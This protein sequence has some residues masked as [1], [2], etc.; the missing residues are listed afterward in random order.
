MIRRLSKQS[1]TKAARELASR[2]RDL[3]RLIAA[4]GIPPLW[5]RQPGFSTLIRIILEQQV[6]LASAKA[7][8]ERLD[9]NIVPFGPHRFLEV[10]SSYLRSVGITRQKA[11]YCIY[12]AEAILEH[13]LDLDALA[14]LEDH[15]AIETLM[16]IK[17]IGSWTAEIYLLMALLRPDIWPAGDIALVKSIQMLKGSREKPSSSLMH[18]MA[19]AWRPYRSVAARILWHHDLSMR[20]RNGR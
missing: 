17:G 5:D 13:Q 9:V 19:D 3:A 11:S 20:F 14:G 18:S 4:N 8:Y 7:I 12:V 16:R 2:D 6:S 10:G 1:L 15:A